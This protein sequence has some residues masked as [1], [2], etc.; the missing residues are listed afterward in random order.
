MCINCPLYSR[1]SPTPPLRSFAAPSSPSLTVP[2]WPSSATL[3]RTDQRTQP[4]ST[5]GFS[6]TSRRTS[7]YNTRFRT[8][9]LVFALGRRPHVTSLWGRVYFPV[10]F[11]VL[12]TRECVSR[13]GAC[14]RTKTI[15]VGGFMRLERRKLRQRRSWYTA[16]KGG[17]LFFGVCVGDL[18]LFLLPH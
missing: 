9:P 6:S 12:C 8:F 1:R 18:D 2:S 3:A 4:R 13:C 17:S 15:G 11:H 14:N 10:S 5:R 7:E 16:P